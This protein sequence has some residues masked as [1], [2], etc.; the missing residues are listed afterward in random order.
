V[1]D[2]TADE[3]SSLGIAIAVESGEEVD[4]KPLLQSG[5][6]IASGLHPYQAEAGQ[7][8]SWLILLEQE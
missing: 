8:S 1:Q 3:K 5:E 7:N 2:Q 4:R 6:G